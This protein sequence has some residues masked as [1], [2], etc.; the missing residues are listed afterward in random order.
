[1]FQLARP[2]S[3]KLL[4]EILSRSTKG[5]PTNGLLFAQAQ[6]MIT[7]HTFEELIIEFIAICGDATEKRG[8]IER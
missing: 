1:M 7:L 2:L 5:L 6:G 8:H 4:I 3:C